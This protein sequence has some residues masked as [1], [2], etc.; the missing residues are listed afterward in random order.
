MKNKRCFRDYAEITPKIHVFE[1]RVDS[2]KT[3]SI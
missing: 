1:A 3:T 2:R